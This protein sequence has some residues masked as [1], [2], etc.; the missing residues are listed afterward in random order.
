MDLDLAVRISQV[1]ASIS[2]VAVSVRVFSWTRRRDKADI[3]KAFW[4]Q[5]QTLN[6]AT[7][8]NPDLMR[9]SEKIIYGDY[10]EPEDQAIADY[11]LFLYLNR[12]QNFYLGY[13]NNLFGKQRYL[14]ATRSTLKLICSQKERIR[15]L[16][17]ERGYSKEFA[18]EVLDRLEN[19]E[20]NPPRRLDAL[21]GECFDRRLQELSKKTF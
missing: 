14:E 12:I 10:I 20:M 7:V 5:A 13:R 8:A 21:G 19:E 4:E 2:I 3:Q 1:I 15:Y 17:I 18:F 9:V 16:L 6:L 11:F